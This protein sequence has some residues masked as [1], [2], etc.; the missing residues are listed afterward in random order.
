MVIMIL[1]SLEP[2]RGPYKLIPT[3]VP[4]CLNIYKNQLD[5][6]ET[7][8]LDFFSVIGQYQRQRENFTSNQ[9]PALNAYGKFIF[10][11]LLFQ[12]DSFYTRFPLMQT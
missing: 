11:G 10:T 12:P 5:T 9:S 6:I 7:D 3:Q 4:S 1:K 8:L 2:S